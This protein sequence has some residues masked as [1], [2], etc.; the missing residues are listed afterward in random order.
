M[1]DVPGILRPPDRVTAF[2]EGDIFELSATGS[3][4]RADDIR[5]VTVPGAATL[6]VQMGAP[7]SALTRVRLRWQ[8]PAPDHARLLS[9]HWERGYGDLEWRGLVPE[10]IMPWYFL[11]NDGSRTHG[12]GVKTDAAAMCFWQVDG[13]GISFWLDVRNG[14][15]GV[16]L[17]ER[18]LNAATI[19]VRE[20]QEEESPFA[21]ACAFCR[22][23]CDSPRLPKQPVYGS[24]NWYYAYGKSSHSEILSDSRLVASLAPD[25]D[26]RPFMVI[27]DGWQQ[28]RQ[29]SGR[30]CGGGPWTAGNTAF[31]DMPTLAAEMR[32][33]GVQPGLWV[34]P[35][36]TTEEVPADWRLP[37]GR[38]GR[39][40]E[41]I[42]LDPT[43]P[44]VL[45]HIAADIRRVADWGY[46]LIKHD[47]TT[48]DLLGRWGREMGADVT[49]GDWHFAD[50]SR[51]TAEVLAALYACLRTAAGDD[52]LLLGCN[53]VGH[54]GAGFFEIQR[55]GDDTSGRDWERTRKMGVNTLAFRM[56]QHDAF[57][58]VDAD[59][60]GLT[61]DVPWEF[62][63]QW[64]DLLARSGTPLFVSA[65]PD[66]VGPEQRRALQ[67]AFW[68]AAT[69]QPIAEPLDWLET[70]CPRRWRMGD[71]ETH[72]DWSGSE[73]ASPFAS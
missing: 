4:W 1:Y 36:L 61:Q 22:L 54:L 62:N 45:A 59:C 49:E 31:P 23:L 34:R 66:A 51:T 12:Y 21:A 50:R 57:F 16:R 71:Q 70:T 13:E 64:L 41:G 43:V 14:A 6:A 19:I 10:R 17:G 60:V 30:S 7:Q 26:N 3:D 56:P 32:G 27:D 24:N 38:F 48:Y 58:A 65:S 67:A 39:V 28:S 44:D 35:L 8:V 20:G 53:T 73:G 33:V 37:A 47:F 63:R 68:V 72:Y 2:T 18:T 9:D 5:V 46:A 25:S 29:L 15:Q 42:L 52:A 11:L 69:P 55:T 40:D